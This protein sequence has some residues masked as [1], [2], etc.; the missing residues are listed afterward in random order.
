[1]ILLPGAARK[2]AV[3]EDVT[4]RVLEVGDVG[5]LPEGGFGSGS[6]F[7]RGLI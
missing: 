6:A 5:G 4:S 2:A 7:A 3:P 1:M